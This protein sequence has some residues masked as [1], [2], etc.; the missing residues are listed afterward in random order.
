MFKDYL[1]QCGLPGIGAI[2]FGM[3]ACHF[4]RD[5]DD[6]VAAL[7]PYFI[8]GLS[9][10]ERCLWVT[11]PPLPAREAMRALGDAWKG[12][13]DAVQSGA[14][15][16]LDFDQWYA[17]PALQSRDV[18]DL[19]LDEEKHALDD[20]YTGLRIA[21]NASSL[22][23]DVWARFMEYERAVTDAFDG[24]RTVVLCCYALGECNDGKMGEVLDAHRCVFTRSDGNWHIGSGLARGAV[25]S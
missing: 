6:L 12:V 3:H 13:D 23:P 11:A 24:R 5:R 19:W 25:G 20:G 2:P 1:T 9:R 16:T 17:N 10:G 21:K 15:R 22:E 18:L 4:Y 14:L 8:A 7:V